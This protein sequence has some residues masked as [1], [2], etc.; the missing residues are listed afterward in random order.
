[1]KLFKILSVAAFVSNAVLYVHAHDHGSGS[2]DVHGGDHE[3]KFD[4]NDGNGKRP[5]GGF[6]VQKA[7]G[8]LQ[9]CPS[10]DCKVSAIDIRME[11]LFE[12]DAEGKMTKN[13]ADSFG[14]IDANW[15]LPVTALDE[16]G[17]NVTSS[18]F[19]AILPVDKSNANVTY[20][21]FVAFYHGNSTAKNGEQ[22][23]DVPGGALKFAVWINDWPFLDPTNKLRLGLRV[24]KKD[25]AGKLTKPTK[26][27]K[28]KGKGR[29]KLIERLSFG[30]GMYLDSPVLAEIDGA[31]Q[32]ITSFTEADSES[33]IIEYEFPKFSKLYYDPVLSSDAATTTTDSSSSKSASDGSLRSDATTAYTTAMATLATVVTATYMLS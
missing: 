8:R 24:E 3:I 22:I 15:T 32:N 27:E 9:L 18:S 7:S 25:N 16:N 23:I 12:I 31:M 29:D 11:R 6:G 2:D 26:G 28:E 19:E 20:K 21:T 17:V 10:G 14:K 30:D 5:R 4:H 33:V 13:K 1:M